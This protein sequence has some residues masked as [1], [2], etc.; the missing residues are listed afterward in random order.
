MGFSINTNV[1]SFLATQHLDNYS[2]KVD[3][4]I[5]SIASGKKING[6]GDFL[7][8]ESIANSFMVQSSALK[9]SLSNIKHGM[10]LADAAEKAL[11]NSESMLQSMRQLAVKSSNGA[12]LPRTGKAL[13][14]KSN[15]TFTVTGGTNGRQAS[16]SIR[17]TG[18]TEGS[19]SSGALTFSGAHAG[20]QASA[21][22]TISDAVAGAN[23]QGYVNI[24]GGS[25]GGGNTIDSI[26]IDGGS[27]ILTSTVT[28]TGNNNS[29]I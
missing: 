19:N 13:Y 26:T 18:A 9:T 14:S 3:S 8:G 29:T 11:E 12:Y 20:T 22:L 21:T 15:A 7:K 16:G 1:S 24:T 4:A 2:R 27:N 23:A 28:H 10:S 6:A 5:T 17:L 25:A